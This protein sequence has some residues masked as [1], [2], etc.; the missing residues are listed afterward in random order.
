MGL[1][2][3]GSGSGTS[4]LITRRANGRIKAGRPHAS[5]RLR[6][7]SE[8]GRVCDEACVRRSR[9]ISPLYSHPKR[10]H[11]LTKQSRPPR[12][13]V[14]V[15]ASLPYERLPFAPIHLIDHHVLYLL[16]LGGCAMRFAFR[17]RGSTCHL[18][19][20]LI[21]AALAILQ[22]A[23]VA[24]DYRECDSR[25]AHHWLV[26]LAH[27]LAGSRELSY[28]RQVHLLGTRQQHQQGYS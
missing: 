1:R 3:R 18:F 7:C 25:P 14:F 2:R 20:T 24:L 6:F 16:L 19:H 5:S 21:L 13:Q 11:R 17:T 22:R 10:E 9:F 28:R 27:R 15:S 26:R 8:G 4:K 23:Q 12:C